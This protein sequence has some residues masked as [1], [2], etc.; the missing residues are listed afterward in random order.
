MKVFLD[1]NVLVAAF[2]TR[3]LCSDV[4]RVVA[5]EHELLVG[6]P[7]LVEMRRILETKLRMPEQAR[8]EALRVLRRYT[9][10]PAA[11][12]PIGLDINDPADEWI[13]A[14]ALTVPA[15]VF[16]TG[17]KALLA[18]RRVQDMPIVSPRD[19]WTQARRGSA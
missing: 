9:K 7:V 3:G 15:D 13:V 14:C 19:F 12:A 1:T 11:K 6:E 5:A 2:A 17:D 4:F 16:V 18:L 10:V 8:N